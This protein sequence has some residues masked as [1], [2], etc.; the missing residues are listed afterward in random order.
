[1]AGLALKGEYKP[2]VV[3]NVLHHVIWNTI[4]KTI[5]ETIEEIEKALTRVGARQARQ[6][7]QKINRAHQLRQELDML[8]ESPNEEVLC[9]F[10]SN[11]KEVSEKTLENLIHTLRLLLY[12]FYEEE[13]EKIK[14]LKKVIPDE[15][16]LHIER[17]YAAP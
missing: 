15:G 5:D 14:I 12:H 6:L 11:V 4:E 3:L 8:W 9:Q 17:V 2:M 13:D 1:M 7:Q 16:V 10:L